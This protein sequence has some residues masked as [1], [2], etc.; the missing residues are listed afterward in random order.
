MISFTGGAE[1]FWLVVGFGGQALFFMRFFVQWLASE[2]AKKSVIPDAF[3][4]FSILG[5]TIL[6]VYAI[7]RRDPVFIIGQGT[8]LI[9]YFRNLYFIRRSKKESR[10]EIAAAL[11]E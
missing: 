5:G 3:W 2:K 9:I 8:G 4:Y 10:R 1:D 6:T 11:S 7:S